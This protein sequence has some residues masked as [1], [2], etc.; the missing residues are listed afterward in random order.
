MESRQ[1][2]DV[3]AAAHLTGRSRP[4]PPVR[5]LPAPDDLRELVD[6]F[7]VPV[8]DVPP[9]AVHRQ[10]TLRRP[11]CQLVVASGYAR[12]Y[13]VEA[14]SSF[15][16]LEGRGWAVGAALRPAAG[17]LLLGRPVATAVDQQLDVV[18]HPQLGGA[19]L[20]AGV[21]AAM[22]VPRDPT[23]QEAAVEL[24]ADVLRR[25]LPVDA[26]GREANALVDLV[27]ADPSLVRVEQLAAAVGRS[28]RSLQRL[29]RDR[30]GLSP[31]WLLQRRRLHE[32]SARL[33]TGDVD[34]AML[35]VELGYADQA[36]FTNDWTRVTGVSPGAYAADQRPPLA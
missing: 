30:I 10:Q 3:L 34:L 29:C 17:R 2:A 12:L 4:T 26:A 36:H 15:V 8:W 33:Q 5:Q 18:D 1:A 9:G 6:W 14:G 13:G 16:E 28:E 32:A 7:W 21:R 27:D 25:H 35:A 24:V 11:T 22:A 20:V 31:K 23:A 19:E